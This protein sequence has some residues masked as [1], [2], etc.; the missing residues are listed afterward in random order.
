[1]ARIEPRGNSFRFIVYDG[2]DSDGNQITHKTTWKPAPG[3]TKKQ[4]EKEL[5]K[6]FG[7]K[8]INDDES[9]ALL[10]LSILLQGTF[11]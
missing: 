8:E 1:M 3:M 9:T 4:A 6:P 11:P 10:A 5:L 2:Y 7:I